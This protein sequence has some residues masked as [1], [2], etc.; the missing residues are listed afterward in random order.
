M[1]AYGKRRNETRRADADRRANARDDRERAPALGRTHAI[2]VRRIT[3]DDSPGLFQTES[4]NRPVLQLGRSLLDLG[5]PG[6]V[7]G[8]VVV[9]ALG[10]CAR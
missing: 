10:V 3:G 5:R 4:A 8:G 6:G 7:D 9:E 1:T 2:V